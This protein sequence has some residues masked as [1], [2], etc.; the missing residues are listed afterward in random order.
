MMP[1]HWWR[2]REYS[3][4]SGS[5]F[6]IWLTT[7][8]RQGVWAPGLVLAFWAVAAK[9]FDAFIK[10]PNLDIPTHLFGGLASAY[11]F[12]VCIVNLRYALGQIHVYLR[13]ALSFSLVAV[14]AIC[15]EFAEF[16]SD[17]FLGSHLN[18][19]VP[20]T[21]GDLFFGLVGASCFVILRLVQHGIAAESSECSR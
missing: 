16:L 3:S 18:L 19:G 2:E 7:S 15:W 10:Y 1:N 21:L 5:A 13:L 12:D 4:M 8:L 17:L 14:I 9:G 11:F 20:D 6:R